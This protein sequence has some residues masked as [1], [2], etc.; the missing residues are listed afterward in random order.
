M[1][2]FVSDKSFGQLLDDISP[3]K[4]LFIKTFNSEFSYTEEFSYIYIF[5]YISYGLL[6]KFLN[7]WR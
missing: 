1:Y 7:Q 2:I 3:K 5:P 4:I 6:V